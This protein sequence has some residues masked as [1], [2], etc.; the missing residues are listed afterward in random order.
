MALVRSI[1][2][3]E[4]QISKA[5]AAAQQDKNI[6]ETICVA[7]NAVCGAI[8]GI[9]K[10]KKNSSALTDK[11]DPRFPPPYLIAKSNLEQIAENAK[12][13]NLRGG[14]L[15]TTQDNIPW[16][17]I[18]KLDRLFDGLSDHAACGL[19]L[20]TQKDFNNLAIVFGAKPNPKDVNYYSLRIAATDRLLH[21]QNIRNE[22][23]ELITKLM[24]KH[25]ELVY[26]SGDLFSQ[27]LEIM[28]QPG[29]P[30]E[31][32]SKLDRVMQFY[33]NPE[34]TVTLPSPSPALPQTNF[35]ATE[36]A[37]SPTKSKAA[38]RVM[39]V[40]QLSPDKT[41]VDLH[42]EVL[43]AC[44]GTLETVS[45]L[46]VAEA[47]IQKIIGVG[48]LFKSSQPAHHPVVWLLNPGNNLIKAL[49][50]K[51]ILLDYI[52]F[53]ISD[54]Q[55][56]ISDYENPSV[57][58]SLEFA[59][60]AQLRL[61]MII[62][63]ELK[64]YQHAHEIAKTLKQL[65]DWIEHSVDT[66]EGLLSL[67]S[68]LILPEVDIEGWVR[69]LQHELNVLHAFISNFF[70]AGAPSYHNTDIPS[71]VAI[72]SILKVTSKIKTHLTSDE[73]VQLL[74]WL[75]MFFFTKHYGSLAENSIAYEML[76]VW[77]GQLI[78]DLADKDPVVLKIVTSAKYN[79]ELP[80]LFDYFIALRLRM[81]HAS[82]H[83]NKKVGQVFHPGLGLVSEF[84]SKFI[85]SCS[86]YSLI[87]NM[88]LCLGD[89]E[90]MQQ[91]S[92]L[93][94][95]CDEVESNF[96]ILN[97]QVNK[98]K[99]QIYQVA[100]LMR[101]KKNSEIEPVALEMTSALK[102][103][104]DNHG[105]ILGLGQQLAAE[106]PGK[107]YSKDEKANLRCFRMKETG[108]EEIVFSESE[109]DM[110]FVV[111]QGSCN[112]LLRY[113]VKSQGQTLLAELSKQIV[114]LENKLTDIGVVSEKHMLIDEVNMLNAKLDSFRELEQA[115]NS[116]HL[117]PTE[118]AVGQVASPSTPVNNKIN[119]DIAN[120][121]TPSTKSFTLPA[122]TTANNE[123]GDLA[124][125]LVGVHDTSLL[126]PIKESDENNTIDISGANP[127]AIEKI[128]MNFEEKYISGSYSVLSQVEEDL[129]NNDENQENKVEVI[130]K[131]NSLTP[132]LQR[133][134][135]DGCPGNTKTAVLSDI[136]NQKSSVFDLP[137]MNRSAS[138]GSVSVN[139]KFGSS[140]T[141]YR[142]ASGRDSGS[143]KVS[144]LDRVR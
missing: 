25:D 135:S 107:V 38:K 100:K 7:C 77:Q 72:L 125:R 67:K 50:D 94:I 119:I 89:L 134:R 118:N 14:S 59:F 131:R 75:R 90:L 115:V 73:R 18:N 140:N 143:S 33:S 99:I 37:V 105:Y 130:N 35:V 117:T 45:E 128:S 57:N 58:Q 83:Y 2:Q 15:F 71:A 78:K 137:V 122:E 29:S 3:W 16:S 92:A 95:Y 43:E 121:K 91:K 74:S 103:E 127:P 66:Q 20:K 113:W 126:S 60:I 93:N 63:E 56:I 41:E 22:G 139:K 96:E 21:Y 132:A 112:D 11:L 6:I 81:A 109:R 26:A 17:L 79:N 69:Q 61:F 80:G 98:F 138:D 48:D 40:L 110:L 53:A 101:E 70:S 88:Q 42:N 144:A 13:L 5:I 31:R 97:D 116:Q 120:A 104:V 142:S 87:S 27:M 47:N 34:V 106:S 85:W 4:V 10:L 124:D 64:P 12:Q 68:L 123:P 24:V 84:Q 44:L 51:S 114:L 9:Y 76:V 36:L 82:L 30:A 86:L 108:P 133:S 129:E 136:T 8:N 52:K 46:R 65:R 62:G 1:E 111:A 49:A 55:K 102:A 23:L 28:Q 141:F 54:I 32:Q 19:L 39:D